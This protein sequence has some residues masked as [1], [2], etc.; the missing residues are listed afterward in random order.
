[1]QCEAAVLIPH[2]Q[3]WPAQH[4]SLC[5][6]LIAAIMQK[7][8]MGCSPSAVENNL[9]GGASFSRLHSDF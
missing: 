6:P 7:N 8:P 5:S 4:K 9:E 3:G 1:M 2:G